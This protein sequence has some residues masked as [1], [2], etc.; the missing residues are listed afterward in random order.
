M[1]PKVLSVSAGAYAFRKTPGERAEGMLVMRTKVAEL[2]PNL[3]WGTTMGAAAVAMSDP[4]SVVSKSCFHRRVILDTANG[5]LSVSYAD[6]GSAEGPVLLFIPGMFASRYGSLSIH[7]IAEQVGVRLLV[8]DRFGMGATSNVPLPK[9]IAAWVDLFPRFLAHLG[10]PRVTLVSH[11]AGTIYLFNTLAL[12]REF[13]H[14]Q[15]FV[16]APWIDPAC[17]RSTLWRSMQYM[18]TK[19][20]SIWNQ[21][22]R[23]FITKASPALATSG[24]FFR[25]LAPKSNKAIE[26]ERTFMEVNYARIEKSYGVPRKESAELSSLCVRFMFTEE[27]V[28][29]NSEALYCLRK[30]EANDWGVCSDYAQFAQTVARERSPREQAHLSCLFWRD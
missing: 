9:R 8:V 18:P 2:R 10:I 27:S 11:S 17:S 21:L 30:A 20:F 25:N 7:A 29:A 14:P 28:G 3:M 1:H 5:P 6:I 24:T 12:C 15:V 16:I 26:E 22:P 4:L 19:V 13:V 23:F